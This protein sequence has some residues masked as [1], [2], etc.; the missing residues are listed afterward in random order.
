MPDK[1][2]KEISIVKYLPREP[3][4]VHAPYMPEMDFYTA[5][6]TGNVRK[7][8]QLCEEPFHTKKGLGVLSQ[9]AL[10]N[11]KYHF[12]ISAALIAR[13]C[14]EGG[15]PLSESYG[16]SDYYIRKVDT[17]KS[18]TKLSELHDEMSMAYTT[19]MRKI[20][21][22]KVFS[23]PVASCIDYILEHLDTR[24]KMRDLC[25]LTG[26]SSSYLSRIFKEETGVT[27]TAYILDKKL[28]TA[29]N[30]LDYSEYP[31][32]WITS[33]LAFPS[34]SYFC[35]VFREAYGT[36]PARYRK[37]NIPRGF[38]AESQKE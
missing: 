2:H 3:E 13:M 19:R 21:S 1:K 20:S 33:T 10:Q 36:P 26:L 16:M 30:M 31:I 24:I 29:R 25:A 34:Q 23:R 8:K 17:V 4:S 7:V 12:V 9:N 5:V 37:E 28:E 11:M 14:I 32:S 15:M 38:A 6:K 18:I 27:V 22:D 35:K